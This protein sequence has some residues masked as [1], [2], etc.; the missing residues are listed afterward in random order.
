MAKITVLL[1]NSAPKTLDTDEWPV[2]VE[3]P[4]AEAAAQLLMVRV[5][6]Q[7]A[8]V[9]GN[10]GAGI[11]VACAGTFSGQLVTVEGRTEAQ[12]YDQVATAIFAVGTEL[13]IDKQLLWSLISKLPSMEL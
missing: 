5:N 13:K 7:R 4:E 12:N 6:G 3:T 11:G 1:S 2:L 8:V 9:Y 10:R